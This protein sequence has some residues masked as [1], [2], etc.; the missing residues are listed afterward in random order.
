M[1][2]EFK[3]I[4]RVEFTE[5]DMAGIVH[6]SMFFQY[7]EQCEHAF[8]RSLGYSVVNRAEEGNAGLPRISA[9][10]DYKKPFRFED[11]MEIQLLVKEKRNRS[12]VYLF[13]FRKAGEETIRAQGKLAV[14]SVAGHPATG[15]RAVALPN[16]MTE[17]I[18]QAPTETLSAFE[19]TTN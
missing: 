3:W 16:H 13:F 11:E 12:L 14:V 18:E 9:H 5:T 7:M 15:M 1:A 4:R 6:F 10:M 8:Y 19:E 2:F 17:T